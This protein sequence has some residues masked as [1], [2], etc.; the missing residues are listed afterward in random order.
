[1]AKS[2]I[3]ALHAEAD[4]AAALGIAGMMISAEEFGAAPTTLLWAAS[5]RCS[6]LSML[7]KSLWSEVVTKKILERNVA[8]MQ[9]VADE[10][11]LRWYVRSNAWADA[12]RM[13]KKSPVLVIAESAGFT[14]PLCQATEHEHMHV[15]QRLL[16]MRSDPFQVDASGRAPRHLAHGKIF[17]TIQTLSE[18]RQ[19]HI[20]SSKRST[21]AGTRYSRCWRGARIW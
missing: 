7:P 5:I 8:N 1:M 6:A 3:D 11:T 10:H 14:S 2:G 12:S 19:A 13:M 16:C 4:P 9:A 21:Y 18:H 15:L 17:A 20:F